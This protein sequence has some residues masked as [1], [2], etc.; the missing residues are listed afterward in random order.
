M[1]PDD[2]EASAGENEVAEDSAVDGAAEKLRNWAGLL[3]IEDT[4]NSEQ[5]T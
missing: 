4:I 5:G 1:P 2:V 3:D